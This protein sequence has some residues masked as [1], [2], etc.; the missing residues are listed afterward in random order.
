MIGGPGGCQVRIGVFLG[1]V[2]TE[3]ISWPWVFLINLPIAA[4]VL[5]AAPGLMP[6]VNRQKRSGSRRGTGG[7]PTTSGRFRSS[8]AMNKAS[9]PVYPGGHRAARRATVPVD[10]LS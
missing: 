6:G 8:L 5:A 2:I 7:L 10:V 4:L 9:A 1:G 3:W